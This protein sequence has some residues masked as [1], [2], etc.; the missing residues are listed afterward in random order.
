MG[1]MLLSRVIGL[2]REWVLAQTVGATAKTDVYYAS[3]TI[4]DFL[5][6][7]MASG[8]LSISF[9][10]ILSA[11][12]ANGENAFANR[13]FRFFSTFMGIILVLF[14]I[15]CEVFA[16]PLAEVVA[17][18]FSPAQHEQ[19]THLIRI[20]LPAQLFFYWG[21]LAISV[22]HT[23]GKFLLPAIAPLVYNTGIII[24]GLALQKKYGVIGFSYGVLL[25]SFVGHGILQW[26]G[27][28][29]LGYSTRPLL[30]FG[31]QMMTVFKRY[32]WISIP[33]MLGF[34]IVLS[35]EWFGKYFATYL[36]DRSVS[37]LQYARTEMRIPVAIIGQ[38]A[39][40]AS[41][42]FL[43]RYWNSGK[44]ELYANTLL[45]EI[46]RMWA[47]GLLAAVV[48]VTHALPITHFIYGGGKFTS[49]DIEQT[50]VILQY[51]S[52]GIF[53]LTVQNLLSRGF[54]ACQRTWLPSLVGTAVSVL[55][56]GLYWK[57]SETMGVQ[58]LAL[59]GS[60]AFCIYATLL[61]LLLRRH[62]KQ[63]AP[64]LS[65]KSFGVFCAAWLAVVAVLAVVSQGILMSGIYQNTRWSGL[66]DAV[67]ATAVVAGTG[68]LLLRTVF[69]RMTDGP[70]F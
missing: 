5:N 47:A 21:G 6:H 49:H 62:L 67:V 22:Q 17:P 34:S 26:F 7:L 39:G 18:G 4:P 28:R 65:F 1:S 15:L 69:K 31:S 16:Y 14:V 27:V 9:I 44:Y 38:A 2:L 64:E 55:T 37:W 59:A 33:I 70:L 8:A 61:A 20:I 10:P 41:F 63:H 42:P 13:V 19:L 11:Y 45:R 51:F 32:I 24:M 43:A 57:L 30:D 60:I 3:F 35:D 29:R 25:G 56:V 48:F 46:Q 52:I 40:I 68:L 54:Y 58:G 50:A 53:F 66:L 12:L 23:H 36:G